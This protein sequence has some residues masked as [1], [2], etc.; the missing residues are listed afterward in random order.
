MSKTELQ[1]ALRARWAGLKP[2]ERQG[3][4]AAAAL[5]LA[6][7][8]WSLWLQPLLRTLREAPPQRAVLASQLQQMR[9]LATEVRSLR[10]RPPLA[11]AQAEAA[12]QAAT[13]ALGAGN[14]VQLQGER[15]VVT[16]QGVSGEALLGW[17]RELRAGARALPVEL[18]LRRQGELYSGSA[19]IALAPAP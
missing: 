14:R 1:A 6:L 11:P 16:L 15:A 3:L 8:L 17:L 10:E 2:S 7:L 9:Q 13:A 5:L 12:L 18:K 4:A 19:V